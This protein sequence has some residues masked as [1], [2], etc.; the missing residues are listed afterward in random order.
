MLNGNE[1]YQNSLWEEYEMETN[2][3]AKAGEQ[4]DQN[5]KEFD[6]NIVLAPKPPAKGTVQLAEL[7]SGTE[8]ERNKRK[9]LQQVS[10]LAAC[11]ITQII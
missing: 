7:H 2:Y 10:L 8:R 6:D 1:E 3:T 5:R 4:S 9:W 11:S